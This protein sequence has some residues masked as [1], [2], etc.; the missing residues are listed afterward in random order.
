MAAGQWRQRYWLGDG[1]A[2]WA[3]RRDWTGDS[4]WARETV[5]VGMRSMRD[6]LVRITGSPP[7]TRG[8]PIDT[9]QVLAD[10]RVE[11]ASFWLGEGDQYG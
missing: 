2:G 7:A 1:K 10:P 11:K 6:G 9:E 4:G 3:R 8:N 5:R